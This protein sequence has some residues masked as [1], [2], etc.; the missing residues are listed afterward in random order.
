M[1]TEPFIAVTIGTI[2][3]ST[4]LLFTAGCSSEDNSAMAQQG[5]SPPTD[6]SG[7]TQ[8]W[9][10][11]LPA[12]QRFVT[13][14]PGAVLDKNT[15]LVWEQ[16]PNTTTTSWGG[17]TQDCLNKNVGGTR[18]WR[19]PTIVELVSLMDPSL[20]AP[21][22]PAGV[23]TGIS[24]IQ[25]SNYWA[26]STLSSRPVGAWVARFHNGFTGGSDK[27]D[28]NYVWCVRG[29]MQESVY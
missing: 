2:V 11:N 6:L 26:S 25:P 15:G 28:L 12:D 24:G 29:G 5:G 20:P 18:G 7:I 3:L 16:A 21:F 10:K 14:F 4:G 9:N 1:K 17:A 23:F 19:L 27:T 22:V 8:S 13:A